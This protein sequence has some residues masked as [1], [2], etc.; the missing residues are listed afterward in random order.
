MSKNKNVKRF[1]IFYKR[2]GEWVSSPY[3]GVTYSLYELGR[4]PIKD[5]VKYLKNRVLKSKIKI[6]RVAA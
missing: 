4:N 2:N 5:V 3:C 1:G 6:K